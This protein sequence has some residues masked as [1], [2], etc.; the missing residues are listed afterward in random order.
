LIYSIICATRRILGNV[1]GKEMLMPK[2]RIHRHGQ[3]LQ[4]PRVAP[5]FSNP[6]K[7]SRSLSVL[8]FLRV[9]VAVMAAP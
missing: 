4:W 5:S 3:R 1:D 2:A 7:I 8:V 9:P 6:A